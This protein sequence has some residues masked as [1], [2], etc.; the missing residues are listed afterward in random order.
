MHRPVRVGPAIEL[1]R[2]GS[3][4]KAAGQDEKPESCGSRGGLRILQFSVQRDHLHLIIEA[5]DGRALSRGIQGLAIRLAKAV[6][7]I[8]GRRGRVWGDRYHVRTL[9]TPREVRNA[10]VYVLMNSRKHLP[11]IRGLDPCSSAV[12]FSGWRSRIPAEPTRSPVVAAR[13]WLAAV[14]WRLHGLI[15]EEEAPG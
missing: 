13:T 12:W 14:G 9:K 3:R 11:G 1:G 10:L 4:E 8:L 6:N 7:R 15:G 2:G 5:E